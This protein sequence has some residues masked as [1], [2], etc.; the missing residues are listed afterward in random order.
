MNDMAPD[1]NPSSW[2]DVYALVRDSR[3]DVLDAV[4]ETNGRL[5]ILT[6]KFAA[7]EVLHASEAAAQKGRTEERGLIFGF[8]RS[9]IAISV[10]VISAGVAIASIILK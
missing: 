9:T 5:D 8:A 6:I 3:S 2:R 7:H 10:S 4:E 1:T